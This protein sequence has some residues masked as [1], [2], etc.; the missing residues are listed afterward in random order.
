MESFNVAV[1][2]WKRLWE[3]GKKKDQNKKLKKQSKKS[4]RRGKRET[5]QSYYQ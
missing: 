5:L 3:N 4:I 2:A 1:D